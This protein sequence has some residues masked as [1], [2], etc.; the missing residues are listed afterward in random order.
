MV[1]ARV[2]QGNPIP[3]FTRCHVYS[4]APATD[5]PWRRLFG[6]ISG[7]VHQESKGLSHDRRQIARGGNDTPE[8]TEELKNKTGYRF[9]TAHFDASANATY[10][11]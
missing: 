6:A 4:G 9:P 7:A 2:R 11:L 1:A 10:A 5:A 8:W 3:A